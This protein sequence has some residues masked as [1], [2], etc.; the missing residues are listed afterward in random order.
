MCGGIEE[1]HKFEDIVTITK[2]RKT[3]FMS[4]PSNNTATEGRTMGATIK[5]DCPKCENDEVS[6]LLNSRWCFILYSSGGQTKARLFS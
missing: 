6:K 1:G 3:A 4:R 5:E 2:S